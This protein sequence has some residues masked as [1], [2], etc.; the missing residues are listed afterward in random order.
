MSDDLVKRLCVS[1]T[2]GDSMTETITRW[3]QERR[4]AANHIEKLKAKLEQ[5]KE[6]WD[7]TLCWEEE[8]GI[9]IKRS[10]SRSL[11]Q[12]LHEGEKE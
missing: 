3:T 12:I 4:D 7:E 10:F 11:T 2:W 8:H 1:A 6:A 9:D 5:I